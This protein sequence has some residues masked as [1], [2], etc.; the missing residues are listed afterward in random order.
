MVEIPRDELDAEY[1]YQHD[2]A[3]KVEGCVGGQKEGQL[4]KVCREIE[5][6]I[7]ETDS[8]TATVILQ[9]TEKKTIIESPDQL[10]PEDDNT[11]T[12]EY[13]E[14]VEFQHSEVPLYNAD[15]KPQK[16][17]QS[18][19]DWPFAGEMLVP[20]VKDWHEES[21]LRIDTSDIE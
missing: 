16:L 21:A 20:L 12:V 19:D 15:A 6:T 8:E 4:W 10:G 11:E 13:P 2:F 7:H 17:A 3:N 9:V 14:L 18:D 5:T 1:G